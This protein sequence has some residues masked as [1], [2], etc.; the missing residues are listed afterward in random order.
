MA[1]EAIN[2][3]LVYNSIITLIQLNNLITKMAYDEG[4]AHRIREQISE[5]TD[6]V[7]KNMFGGLCFM[8]AGHMAF[9]IVKNQLMAR[10]GPNQ[11]EACLS[12]P[13]AKE[14]DF[15]GKAMK[16]MI[17][18]SPD[19]LSDDSDLKNWLDTCLSFIASLPPK[20]YEDR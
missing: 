13:H 4:L 18:V 7:E 3:P 20:Q 6:V 8:V 10:V 5:R 16:G 19:G 11:Y 17:Y 1:N 14:M 15:T 9:G 2:Y 12:K